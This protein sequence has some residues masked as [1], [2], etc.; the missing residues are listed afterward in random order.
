MTCV[1]FNSSTPFQASVKLVK[2]AHPYQETFFL[3]FLYNLDKELR[4]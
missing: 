1:T 2:V 4:S 3:R